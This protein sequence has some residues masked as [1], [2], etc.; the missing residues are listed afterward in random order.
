MKRSKAAKM[1]SK[2]VLKG[3]STTVMVRLVDG[4][5]PVGVDFVD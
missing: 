5:I 4:V 3:G 2:K 1:N